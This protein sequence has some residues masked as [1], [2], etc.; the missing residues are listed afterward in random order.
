E[1]KLRI[2]HQL[3]KLNVDVIEAGFPIASVGDF[4]AVKKVAES[5]KGPQIAG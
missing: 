3:E 1:E 4:E 2:A 5:I